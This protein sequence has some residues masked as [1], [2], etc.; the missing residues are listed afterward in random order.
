MQ[1][2]RTGLEHPALRAE[3]RE[4]ALATLATLE[5]DLAVL[6][7]HDAV[8]SGGTGTRRLALAIT[9]GRGTALATRLKALAAVVAPG[10]AGRL[11]RRRDRRVWLGAGETTVEHV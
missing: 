7:L 1:S 3:E 4:T 6:R 2:L 5:R 9:F 11:V 8:R 10:L